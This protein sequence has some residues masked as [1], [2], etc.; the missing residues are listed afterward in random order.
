MLDSSPLVV[1]DDTFVRKVE[2]L[3]A[4]LLCVKFPKTRNLNINDLETKSDKS[5]LCVRGN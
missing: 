5:K 1:E 4:L 2:G 3:V